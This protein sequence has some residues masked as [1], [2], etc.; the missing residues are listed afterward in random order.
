MQVRR[1]IARDL[2][3][4]CCVQGLWFRGCGLLGTRPKAQATALFIPFTGIVK[5]PALASQPE[6]ETASEEDHLPLQLLESH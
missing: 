4:I 1:R 6:E 2:R 3:S 5:N